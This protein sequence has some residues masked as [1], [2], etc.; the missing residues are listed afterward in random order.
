MWRTLTENDI[1]QSVT[2]AERDA[3]QSA[4]TSPGQ[5]LPVAS[6]ILT[7]VHDARG[8]I[9]AY[10]GNTLAEGDTVPE[11]LVHHV[12]AIIRWRLLTRLPTDRLA[13]EPR[14]LEY[15]EALKA[16]E[17]VAAG[18]Y[19]IE[20]PSTPDDEPRAQILPSISGRTSNFK[21]SQQDGI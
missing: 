20:S 5:P 13:T 15:Q 6:V 2:G 1:L 3:I 16:L 10:R 19:A 4:A 17:S 7:A 12:V 18:R 8:R 21:R 14:K 9:A 11:T